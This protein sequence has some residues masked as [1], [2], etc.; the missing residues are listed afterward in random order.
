MHCCGEINPPNSLAESD[1]Q[2]TRLKIITCR[3]TDDRRLLCEVWLV[4]KVRNTI[5]AELIIITKRR[6]HLTL[7]YLQFSV[8]RCLVFLVR[9]TREKEMRRERCRCDRTSC[10]IL[11]TALFNVCNLVRA[12]TVPLPVRIAIFSLQM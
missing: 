5:Q 12:A 10:S 2:S 4:S 7:I 1:I 8:H 11:I 6:P 9:G 3:R